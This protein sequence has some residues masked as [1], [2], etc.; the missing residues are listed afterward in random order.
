MSGQ[1]ERTTP[2]LG[3]LRKVLLASEAE[4]LARHCYVIPESLEVGPHISHLVRLGEGNRNGNL[5]CC[6]GTA[7]ISD[8]PGSQFPSSS[9]KCTG[10]NSYRILLQR[11]QLGPLV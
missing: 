4:V 3:L 1:G 7:V 2:S 9:V 5:E 6:W 10:Q 11:E 8:L